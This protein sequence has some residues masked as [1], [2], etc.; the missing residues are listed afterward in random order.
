[1]G[2]EDMGIF[3]EQEVFGRDLGMV[4]QIGLVDAQGDSRL[5]ETDQVL[6]VYEDARRVVGVD[7]EDQLGRWRDRPNGTVFT[8]KNYLVTYRR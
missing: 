4:V 6:I 2:K 3:P 8:R 1:M 7:D 5:A